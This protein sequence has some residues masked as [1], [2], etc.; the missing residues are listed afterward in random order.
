[1]L[2]LGRADEKRGSTVW[3]LPGREAHTR[4]PGGACRV[5]KLPA[6]PFGGFGDKSIWLYFLQFDH[7]FEENSHLNL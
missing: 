4:Q 7:F 6:L 3:P 5:I 2:W 1:M